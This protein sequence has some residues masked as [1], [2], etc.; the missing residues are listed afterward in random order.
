ME[1]LATDLLSDQASRRDAA[2][3]RLRVIGA[4]A[5]SR[6]A[7]L[8][9]SDAPPAARAAALSVLEGLDEPRAIDLALAAVA[10][11]ENEVATAA[12]SVLAGWVT[13]EPGTRI[14][15]AVTVVALD[16]TRD[17]EV[18]LAALDALS[19]LPRPLVEPIRAQATTGPTDPSRFD[20]PS[21]ARAWLSARG[22]AAPLSALHDILTSLRERERVD[23]AAGRRDDWRSVRGAVHAAL[24]RRGSSIALY[25]LR[26]TFDEATA[27]LPLDFLSAMTTIGDATCLEPLARAWVAAAAHPQWRTR[28]VEAASDIV[29]RQR[30]TGRHAALKRVR[31]RW[32][33]FL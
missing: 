2:V 14:L 7:A 1:R 15:E 33:G 17:A 29:R 16:R 4:R 8:I 19:E 30:L 27:P 18:R 3:A 10:A 24:A 25:D 6:L 28:L 32:S 11:P 9:G 21:E 31:T 20:D 12:L 13:R 5:L 22:T 23:E 26:E